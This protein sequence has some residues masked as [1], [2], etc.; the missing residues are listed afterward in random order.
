MPESVTRVRFRHQLCRA[1]TDDERIRGLLIGGSGSDDRLDEWSDIDALFFVTD[2][3]FEPF[4]QQWQTWAGQ[5]GELILVYA[6]IGFPTTYWTMYHADPFPQRV[7]FVFRPAS[8]Q[9]MILAIPTSPRSVEAM[10]C[11]D[12]TEGRL[13]DYVRQLVGRSLRLPPAEEQATLK[14]RCDQFWYNLMYAYNKLR[15]GHQWYARQAYHMGALD[16]LMALLKLE[17]GALER[18]Q[19]S[20]PSWNL[21]QAISPTRLVQLN[22]CIPAEGEAEMLRAMFHAAQLGADLC[23]RLAARYQCAWPKRAAE[24]IIRVLSMKELQEPPL[25]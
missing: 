2:D 19:A 13:S 10:V 23:Q 4:L 20:F 24:E 16:C 5:F 15:R 6:P 7:E 17:A 11:C 3:D 21:E 22:A 8:Q 25:L 14:A 12:K 9:E 18:W 1:A